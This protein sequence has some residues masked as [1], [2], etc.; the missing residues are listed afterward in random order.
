MSKRLKKVITMAVFMMLF[1]ICSINAFAASNKK[2]SALYKTFMTK[3]TVKISDTYKKSV[4][5]K[6]CYFTTI[7]IDGNGIKELIVKE[8][9]GN[10]PLWTCSPGTYIF[11]VKNNKVI[12]AGNTYLK[13]DTTATVQ[14]SKK[15]KAIF[16]CYPVASYTPAYFYTLKNGKLSCK[17]FF[18]AQYG[19]PDGKLGNIPHEAWCKKVGYYINKKAVTQK[20]YHTEYNKYKKTLKKYKLYKNTASNRKKILK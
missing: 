18:Y 2:V 11:T 19:Y 1:C 5:L 10:S 12:Y 8:K 3:K 17:M 15:Y 6:D 16:S 7:D 20:K 4:T 13:Q 9:F 14:I